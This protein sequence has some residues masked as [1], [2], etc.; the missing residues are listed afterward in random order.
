MELAPGDTLAQCIN[1]D[2]AVPVEESL[3]IP[4]LIADVFEA[5]HEKGNNLRELKPASAA[6]YFR[7]CQPGG[8]YSRN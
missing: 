5:A 3:T 2:A 7:L 4:K 6:K 1:Q 8:K